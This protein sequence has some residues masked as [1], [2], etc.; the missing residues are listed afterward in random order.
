MT[1]FHVWYIGLPCM[2]EESQALLDEYENSGDPDIADHLIESLDAA[3]CARWEESTARM[4]YSHSSQ[5][6]WALSLIHI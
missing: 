5:K 6:S 3:R 1:Q 2:D 4:N